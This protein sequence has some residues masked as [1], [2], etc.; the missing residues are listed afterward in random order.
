MEAKIKGDENQRRWKLT[1][2]DVGGGH[3]GPPGLENAGI[4]I[5]ANITG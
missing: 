4:E 1:L 3:Y 5:S 2:P